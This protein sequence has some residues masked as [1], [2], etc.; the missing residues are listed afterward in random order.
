MAETLDLRRRRILEIRNRKIS[1]TREKLTILQKEMS[2]LN[3]DAP[4][5]NLISPEKPE[6]SVVVAVSSARK[7]ARKFKDP[8]A[9]MQGRKEATVLARVHEL[10]MAGTWTSKK[11]AKIPAPSRTKTHWDFV[12]EEMNWLSSVILQERKTKKVNNIRITS[13][14]EK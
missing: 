9:A 11:M 10:Q 12:I 4:L 13:K 8:V 1:E 7:S 3:E 6:N 5:K 14:F 2:D